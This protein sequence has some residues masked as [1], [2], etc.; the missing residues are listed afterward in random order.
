MTLGAMCSWLVRDVDRVVAPNCGED[1]EDLLDALPSSWHRGADRLELV[2]RP[3]EAEPDD[4]SA[5]ADL[6]DGGEGTGEQHRCVPRCDEHVGADRDVFGDGR[7][8]G[9]RDEGVD[10][11][12]LCD[13]KRSIAPSRVGEGPR[14]HGREQSVHRPE[15]VEPRGF[16]LD[17]D[18]SDRVW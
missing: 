17:R 8:E 6:I 1:V 7:R 18:G 5:S 10:H 2:D 4:K 11:L 12:L 16:G 9:E 13:G 3:A 15:R 14:C